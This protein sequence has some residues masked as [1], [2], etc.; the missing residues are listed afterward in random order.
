MANMV[1]E[2]MPGVI[3]KKVQGEIVLLNPETGEYF[4]L[5]DSGSS[6][7]EKMDGKHSID[8]IVRMMLD[9]YD[10]E[11]D[12]LRQDVLELVKILQDRCLI[13]VVA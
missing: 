5:N 9:E 2:P 12:S 1:F 10:V 6:F 8:D 3:W 4:G 7:Y 13:R 11:T